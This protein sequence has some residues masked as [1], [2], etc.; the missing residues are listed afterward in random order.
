MK[1]GTGIIFA[2][3]FLIG[4][5]TN[6]AF[7]QTEITCKTKIDSNLVL[8]PAWAFGVLYGGYTIKRTQL[9][10]YPNRSLILT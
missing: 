3:L 1:I 6:Q 10:N 2:L 9:L 8:P 5:A 7:S 4:I